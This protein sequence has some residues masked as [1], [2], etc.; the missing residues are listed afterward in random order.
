[1]R[2]KKILVPIDFSKSS[3]AAFNHAKF[4]AER[5]SAHIDV[6][7]IVDK[8]HVKKMA[9]VDEESESDVARKFCLQAKKRMEAFLAKSNPEA[10]VVEQIIAVGIPFMAIALKAQELASD[11]IVIG[12]QG[13]MGDGKIDKIFFGSTAERVVRVLPCPV[14]CVPREAPGP[15]ES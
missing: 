11:M 14:L 5:F 8:R 3:E 4:L 7:H 13:R 9:E 2:L 15:G 12:G 1:M 10:R 6:I